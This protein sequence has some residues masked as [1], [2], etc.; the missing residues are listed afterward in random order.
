ME[1]FCLCFLQVVAIVVDRIILGGDKGAGSVLSGGSFE[2]S[3]DGNLEG[4]GH[5]EVYT[6][7]VS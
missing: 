4:V 3:I 6:L 7:G 1:E 5:G 2:G